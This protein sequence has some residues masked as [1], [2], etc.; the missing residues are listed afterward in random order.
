MQIP[1]KLKRRLHELG[2]DES[3]YGLRTRKCVLS[4][5]EL[6]LEKVP[7]FEHG[8][9]VP[10]NFDNKKDYYIFDPISLVPCIA[11]DPKKSDRILDM[12]AAPGTKTFIISF[13]TD[14]EAKI[15]ANDINFHRTKRLRHNVNKFA[16]S[17]LVTNTSG[18]KITGHFNK[19]LL[20]APCSGEGIVNKKNK[21]YEHWS[22]K[23]VRL[24]AKKQ[25]KLIMHAFDI[26]EEGGTLVYSTCTF[27]PEENEGVVDFL[28]S[29][30]ENMDL[31]EIKIN[32]LNHTPGIKEWNDK[33][34][35]P[36]VEKCLRVYPRHNNTA[37]FFVAKIVKI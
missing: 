3:I 30:N 12:C 9:F 1:E 20:D 31:D 23:N 33:E 7:W 37:G 32:N 18:R 35:D 5:E 8:Y 26:L 29:E 13:L 6:G 15:M 19:I 14:N 10:E 11:L 4:K 24:M 21:L 25:K 16:I 36:R 27:E 2:L 22:E 28:L 17:A 34:F